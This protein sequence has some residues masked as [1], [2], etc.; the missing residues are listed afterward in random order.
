M[1]EW[2]AQGV[3]GEGLPQLLVLQGMHEVRH[4][5][6]RALGEELQS[7]PD[8]GPL[9]R[10]RRNA[11]QAEQSLDPLLGPSTVVT[12]VNG[13]PRGESHASLAVAGAVVVLWPPGGR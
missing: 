2:T 1:P 13:R 4:R 9:R 5:A 6:A 7:P 10:R 12:P 3:V 11:P 8:R